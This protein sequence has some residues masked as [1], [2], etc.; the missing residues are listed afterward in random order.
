MKSARWSLGQLLRMSAGLFIWSSAFVV[1]YAGFSLGC[2]QLEVP[3]EAGLLNPVTIGLV[4]AFAVHAA[5][6][7][8]LLVYRQRHPVRAAEGEEERSRRLR[9]KVEGLVLWVSLAALLFIAFP[10]L[11]VPP[12]AG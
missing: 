3:L 1:L 7:L 11:L 6:L 12:C 10:V 9:H 2:Q 5:A 4:V 8:A